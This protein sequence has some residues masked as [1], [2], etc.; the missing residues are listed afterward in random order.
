MREQRR[1][2]GPE[3]NDKPVS[4][5]TIL[6][7]S[8][9]KGRKFSIC[10]K[11]LGDPMYQALKRS[12]TVCALSLAAL[13]GIQSAQAE[14]KPIEVAA[15]T[16]IVADWV[17]AVG[18]D[19]VEVHTLIE[20]GSDPHTY[21]PSPKDVAKLQKQAAIFLIGHGLEQPLEAVLDGYKG[22]K[23]AIAEE[24]AEHDDDHDDHGHEKHDEHGHE[25]HG[26]EKHDDHG[27]EKHDDHADMKTMTTMDM[28]ST[29]ITKGMTTQSMMTTKSMNTAVVASSGPERIH[30]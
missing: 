3:A 10:R 15:S 2:A 8:C 7:R 18:G 22:P 17:K 13:V 6:K 25:D 30:P 12:S 29:M 14:E 24:L 1:A 20:S 11:L 21:Q 28:K 9:I 26:H 19:H 27:H 4:R 5:Q 23:V 16:A